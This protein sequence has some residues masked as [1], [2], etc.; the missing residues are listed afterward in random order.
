MNFVGR[1]KELATLTKL[2]KSPK[3]E[4]GIIYGRRRIGKTRLITTFLEQQVEVSSLYWMATT[5]NETIQLRDFSQSIWRYDSRFN[6]SPA[7]DFSFSSWEE[8]LN[9]L[10]DVVE[11]DDRPHFIVLD[12]FTYL[13]RNESAIS[14][15][16]QKVWD[17]RLSKIPQFKLI[18]TGSLIGMMA[19]EVFSYQA[20]LYGRAT[21]QI[22]LK[23]LP[24]SA[25]S[26]MFP[27]RDAAERVAIFGVT[28]GVP[29]YME[30]FTRTGEF[31][32][33]LRDE[34]LVDG[35]M[36]LSDPAVIIYEQ[37]SEPQTYESVL[38][39][40]ASGFHA[41]TDIAKMVG[42]AE[43]G[44][45]HYLGLL[46]E[47]ELIEK[48]RPILAKPNSKTGRYY[49]KDH[50]LRFYYRFIV[51]Q[52]GAIERGYV[53]AAVNKIWAEL[54]GFI[55]EH[56]FEE[57]CREWVWAAAMAGEL[58]F[59]PESV[60]SYWRRH[61]NKGV[62][63]DVVAAA[64][65]EK[66]LLIGEAKWGRGTISRHILTDLIERSQRMPQVEA[67]WATQY[68]LFGREGFT[69]AT[70]EAAKEHHVKLVTLHELEQ[71]LNR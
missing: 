63:L 62:Q 50:F 66:K 18:L 35:S 64:P 61:R 15:V 4:L 13:L 36:M 8:A 44:L 21:A 54:R 14:S 53:D 37:L 42:I 69:E 43:T 22:H 56:V 33:A 2:L 5:H 12:E 31:V 65:R 6:E 7:M 67:G 25:L 55:G 45:G 46:Q 3:A 29:A 28:G 20:P 32:S 19:R 30:L 70:V 52:R 41:W 40:V 17:H 60:G 16:F 39:V 47:L 1:K 24:Y 58:D 11:S 26:A 71:T 38:S 51:P 68:V 27:D 34:C 49:I 10:A 57:L 23:P 48:R 59:V 9:H